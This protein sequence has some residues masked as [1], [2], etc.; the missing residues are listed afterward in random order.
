[1]ELKKINESNCC[2]SEHWMQTENDDN[3][4]ESWRLPSGNYIVKM[5]KDNGLDDNDS[6]IKDGLPAHPGAFILSNSER[7]MNNIIREIDGFY[8]NNIYYTD[9]DSLYIGKKL[10]CF[11]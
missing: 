4:S 2:K 5:K 8:I 11:R 9:T 7:F 6:N 3:V 10:G 1:M